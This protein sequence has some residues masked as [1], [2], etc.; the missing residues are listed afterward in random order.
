M[1]VIHWNEHTIPWSDIDQI[2]VREYSP[3]A[4]YGGWGI[5]YSRNGRA[6]NVR[7]NKGIQISKKNGKRILLGTQHPDEVAIAL[8]KHP[9]LV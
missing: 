5:R 9:L 7:G 6:Y 3:L 8:R 4:E 1:N 2:Y